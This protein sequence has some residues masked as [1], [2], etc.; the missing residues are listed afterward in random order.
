MSHS[1]RVQIQRVYTSERAA[2]QDMVNTELE[3]MHADGCYVE[4][5][6]FH[7]KD[8]EVSSDGR[9]FSG[10]SNEAWIVYRHP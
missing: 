8:M 10:G 1:G 5:V 4:S 6:T 2:L 9:N 7:F 3:K